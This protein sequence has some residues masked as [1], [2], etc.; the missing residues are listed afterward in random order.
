MWLFSTYAQIPYV[1][2]EDS[3]WIVPWTFA[4]NILRRFDNWRLPVTFEC[5]TTWVNLRTWIFRFCV[6]EIRTYEVR[7]NNREFSRAASSR[8]LSKKKILK[9]FEH[10]KKKKKRR[11]YCYC[12]LKQRKLTKEK[13][14]GFVHWMEHCYKFDTQVFWWK[15]QKNHHRLRTISFVWL[16]R[17]HARLNPRSQRRLFR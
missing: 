17:I 13:K 10:S 11:C 4:Y 6:L 2:Y 14:C 5:T 3:D 16:V 12:Y 7:T 15:K 1:L 9:P 8:R